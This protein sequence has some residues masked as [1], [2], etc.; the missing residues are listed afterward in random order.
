MLEAPFHLPSVSAAE[1][2]RLARGGATLI[3]LRKPAAVL[4]SGH[5][6]RGA[7]R[8]NPFEFSHMDPL[9]GAAGKLIAFCVHGREVSQFACALLLLHGRDSCYVTGGYEALVA[10]GAAREELSE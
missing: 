6:I 3:D 10:A 7:L 5:G 2:L 1:A 4:A 9:T 8:R